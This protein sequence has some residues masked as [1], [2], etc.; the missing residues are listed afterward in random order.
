[1]LSQ[2]SAPG[3]SVRH[4]L[5]NFE[6]TLGAITA[7]ARIAGGHFRERTA[8]NLLAAFGELSLVCLPLLKD[9][10]IT[11]RSSRR[12]KGEDVLEER[13]R[14]LRRWKRIAASGSRSTQSNAALPHSG[15]DPP[16]G[17]ICT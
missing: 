8:S 6:A 16:P 10:A 13:L 1:M 15:I 17:A 14:T 11:N 2:T 9:A 3:A 5:G 12:S 4:L 7:L